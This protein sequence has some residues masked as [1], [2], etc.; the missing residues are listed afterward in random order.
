[1]PHH[2][3]RPEPHTD[4]KKQRKVEKHPGRKR[5]PDFIHVAEKQ[6][7]VMPSALPLKRYP[8]VV[9]SCSRKQ[10]Q[11]R[12]A[13]QTRKIGRSAFGA[14]HI[15]GKGIDENGI[16]LAQRTKQFQQKK[17]TRQDSRCYHWQLSG[18][19]APLTNAQKNLERHAFVGRCE[20]EGTG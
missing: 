9:A 20:S 15:S 18:R 5:R 1:M 17:D 19:N 16:M 8:S 3:V 2:W 4:T 12:N 6:K 7:F 14:H 13:F 11:T 10:R